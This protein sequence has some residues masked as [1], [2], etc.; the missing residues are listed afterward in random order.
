MSETK[1]FGFAVLS[2]AMLML[3]A[4]APAADDRVTIPRPEYPRPDLFRENWVTLNG[5][6]QFEIDK[7]ADGESRGLTYGNDLKAKITVRSAPKA[8]SPALGCL[9]RST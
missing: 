7:E 4:A 8:S 1:R 9:L 6:W 5:Q 3:D 2:L